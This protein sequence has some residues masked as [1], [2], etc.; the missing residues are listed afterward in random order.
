M[1]SSASQGGN[2]TGRMF[3]LKDS[4][5]IKKTLA[6]ELNIEVYEDEYYNSNNFGY[7]YYSRRRAS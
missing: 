3:N 1:I 6:N 5:Y 7:Y 4:N 2:T